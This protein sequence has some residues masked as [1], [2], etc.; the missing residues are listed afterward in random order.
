[1]MSDCTVRRKVAQPEAH[2]FFFEVDVSCRS[3]WF[4]LEIGFAIVSI[5]QML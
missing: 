4:K 5:W 1:M 2:I 3:H